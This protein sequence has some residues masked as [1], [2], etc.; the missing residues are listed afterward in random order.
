M[1]KIL[2]DKMPD[3]P[4][5]CPYRM[6]MMSGLYD[7]QISGHRCVLHAKNGKCGKLIGYYDM[8]G[9]QKKEEDLHMIERYAELIRKGTAGPSDVRNYFNLVLPRAME[10]SD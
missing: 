9:Q 10:D 1:T 7:C 4:E 3:R 6:A 8:I 2:V 5:E